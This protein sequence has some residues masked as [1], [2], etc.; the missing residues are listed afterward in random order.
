MPFREVF[1]PKWLRPQET[2]KDP[3][4]PDPAVGALHQI[5]T[6][7]RYTGAETEFARLPT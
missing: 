3:I 4:E 2:E 5:E 7:V 6:G 1:T